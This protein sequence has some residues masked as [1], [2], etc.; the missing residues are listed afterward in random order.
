MHILYENEDWLIED[1]PEG[2]VHIQ[3]K[4]DA[5]LTLDVAELPTLVHALVLSGLMA[6]VGPRLRDAQATEYGATPSEIALKIADAFERALD[7]ILAAQ[8]VAAKSNRILSVV[9]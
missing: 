2:G 1:A 8:P 5:S 9:R 4:G 6:G 7:R 3:R